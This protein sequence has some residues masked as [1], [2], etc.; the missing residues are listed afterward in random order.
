MNITYTEERKYT[1]DEVQRLFLS[2]QWISGQYPKRLY[3]A[4]QHSSTVLTAWDEN[5][6]VGLA[7]VLDDSELLA[8]VHYVLVD[9]AYQG[10]GIASQLV[11]RIKEKYKDYLYI[12]LMPEERAKALFYQKHGLKCMPDGVAMQRCNFADRY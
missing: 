2:V 8:Y 4:L 10:C 1:E 7:R 9:P 12:E 11:E 6:L 5:R 3:K